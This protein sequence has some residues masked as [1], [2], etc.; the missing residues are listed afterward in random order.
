MML[1]ES[2]WVLVAE[3]AAWG[4]DVVYQNNLSYVCRL[5]MAS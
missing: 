2:R 1:G 5:Q 4:P 3:A